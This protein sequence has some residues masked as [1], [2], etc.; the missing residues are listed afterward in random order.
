MLIY[1]I[2][3]QPDICQIFQKNLPKHHCFIYTTLEPIY[4]LIKN[5]NAIPDLIIADYIMNNHSIFNVYEF[6]N[7][8]KLHIPFIYYNDPVISFPDRVMFWKYILEVNDPYNTEL[9]VEKF[10]D[11]FTTI[12]ELVESPD[13]KPYI[14]LL[15]D[16]KPLPKA[17]LINYLYRDYTLSSLG[18]KLYKYRRIPGMTD[19]LFFLLQMFYQNIGF[20]LSLEQL[21]DEYL[22]NGKEIKIPSLKVEL[23]RLRTVLKKSN[24]SRID[25]IKRQNGYEL[26]DY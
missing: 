5:K 1:F 21:Q 22:K 13:L 11:V 24:D 16:P 9:D 20:V 18:D 10:H 6:M 7:E 14:K 4:D 25:I 15:Q 26:I 23:S 3:S 17:K 12:M 2:T 19:G 8:R